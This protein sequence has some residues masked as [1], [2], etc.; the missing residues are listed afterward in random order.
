VFP[1]KKFPKY[2]EDIMSAVR[3]QPRDYFDEVGAKFVTGKGMKRPLHEYI[4]AYVTVHPEGFC[5]A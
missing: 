1:G 2:A 3:K 4:F 5:S